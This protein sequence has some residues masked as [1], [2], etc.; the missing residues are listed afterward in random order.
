MSTRIQGSGGVQG[1][2]GPGGGGP[3]EGSGSGGVQGSAP[4]VRF[5]GRVHVQQGSAGGV[6][7][8]S[9]ETPEG[10]Q[11][12]GVRG[13]QLQGTVVGAMIAKAL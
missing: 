1:S 11:H 4:G 13:V 12:P 3:G 7:P 5:R 2:G 8:G 10:F 9:I 6:A